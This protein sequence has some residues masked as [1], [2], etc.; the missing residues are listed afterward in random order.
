[1]Y[2][3]EE[4]SNFWEVY[5]NLKELPKPLLVH[6]THGADRT[7]IAVAMHRILDEGWTVEAACEEMDKYGFKKMLGFWKKFISEVAERSRT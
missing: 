6:C 5:Q 2:T 4:K 1:M 3:H 7:G